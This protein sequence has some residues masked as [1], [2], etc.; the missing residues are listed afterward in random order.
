MHADYACRHT[1]R[2]CTSGWA[3]PVEAPLHR[4]LSAALTAGRLQVPAGSGADTPAPF[5]DRE[6]RPADA[7]A[8]LATHASG[9]CVFFDGPPANLC[10]LQRQGGV[11]W[12]PASC[13]HFPRVALLD[14]RGTSITL[15]HY[16]PTAAR[17]LFR[18]DVPLAITT[19]PAAFPS[20]VDYEGFDARDTWP[21]LLRPGVLA[22]RGAAAH[23][24][25]DRDAS[26]LD[27]S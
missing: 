20:D 10:A 24:G 25:R 22:R 3:I 7:A 14:G 18:T 6:P 21:P 26:R 16:C 17:Q 11:A 27:A 9:A 5:Q 13:R 1:G 12:L 23:P 2:C 19:A 15:S 4:A 8:I